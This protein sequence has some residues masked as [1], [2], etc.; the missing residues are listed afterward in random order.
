[1]EK[2]GVRINRTRMFRSAGVTGLYIC[3]GISLIGGIFMAW[4]SLSYVTEYYESYGMSVTEGINDVLQYVLSSSGSFFGFAVLLFSAGIIIRK[5]Y[6]IESDA[7]QHMD[8][9][10]GAE[11]SMVNRRIQ[12]RGRR[13][14][15]GRQNYRNQRY[16]SFAGSCRNMKKRGREQSFRIPAGQI[17]QYRP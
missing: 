6:Q 11:Q 16:G 15:A 4:Y 13:R 17:R 9:H 2:K 1:M 12:S 14:D 3:S 10:T 5:M 8:E 7:E